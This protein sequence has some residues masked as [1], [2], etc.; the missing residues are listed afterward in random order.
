MKTQ[1]PK[2]NTKE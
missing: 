1:I 2:D